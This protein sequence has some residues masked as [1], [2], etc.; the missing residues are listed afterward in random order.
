MLF[1]VMPISKLG[2]ARVTFIQFH[3]SVSAGMN[4]QMTTP[5]KL[6]ITCFTF[7]RFLSSVTTYMLL[8]ATPISKLGTAHA[9][10]IRFLFSMIF[11]IMVGQ[12]TICSKLGSM[13][14]VW[15]YLSLCN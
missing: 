5:R 8:Q 4:I 12:M 14:D 3:T 7:I 13:G 11:N 1:Q 6:G 2:T 15:D 10:F 9:T